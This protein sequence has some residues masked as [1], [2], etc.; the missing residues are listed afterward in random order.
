MKFRFFAI[1]ALLAAV[2]QAPE[3]EA[4]RLRA[5]AYPL[6]TI[7]PYTNVWSMTD[8]LYADDTRHWTGRQQPLTG[9][10]SVDG[11]D[12]RFMGRDFRY[13][14]ML[15]PNAEWGKW[16]GKYKKHFPGEG[17]ALESHDDSSWPPGRGSYATTW[18]DGKY[19][20]VKNEFCRPGGG[21]TWDCEDIWVRRYVDLPENLDGKD[22]WLDYCVEDKAEIFINGK[23]LMLADGGNDF[24]DHRLQPIPAGMLRPGRNLVAAHAHHDKGKYGIYDFA[25]LGSDRAAD[26]FPQAAVQTSVDYSA[27]QT[28]YTFD[29]GPV[30]LE[31]TFTAPF[32]PNDLELASRPVNYM[33]YKVKSTDG[34]AHTTALTLI[35]S[36]LHAVDFPG[37]PT[38]ER[39]E[40]TDGL[41]LMSTGTVQQ[42]TLEK[43]GD[44]RR[45]N[46]GR[47]YVAAPS[48]DTTFDVDGKE[49]KLT[50]QLGSAKEAEGFLMLGYDDVFSLN[51]M[52]TNLRPYWNRNGDQ[53]IL[54]QFLKA[55]AD[56]PRL[57]KECAKFDRKLYS[58]AK[59]AG[60]EDYA[61][62]CTLAWRQVMAAHKLCQAP[63]GVLIFPSKE[64]FSNGSIGTVDLSYPSIP[65]FLLYNVELAKG[66]INPIFEYCAS[67]AWNKPYA[68]HDVGRY[69]LALGQNYGGDMPVEESGNMLIMAAAIARA[70]GNA[71]YA[72]RY[73]PLLTQWA[74][75]LEEKG[76]DPENQLC[77][78]DFAGHL[79]HNANLSGKAILGLAA[80]GYLAGMR[81]DKD[82]EKKYMD[83]AREMAARW[84][85]MADDGNH[86]RLAFDKPGTWSQKY[87]LVWDKIFG[88]NIFPKEVYDKEIKYYL[89]HQNEYG[90]PLDCRETYTKTDWI[91]WT[92]TMAD[93]DRDFRALVHPVWKFMNETTDRKP[94]SDWPYT[95]RKIARQFRN[96]SVVGGYFIKMLE[97]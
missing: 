92:A 40:S 63:S 17:W 37:E 36:P 39:V 48:A 66:L 86:Y 11:K 15:V 74:N 42:R 73:W 83:M 59:K 55:Q 8:T 27:T 47:F 50:R 81:G 51:Y 91:L 58:D 6:V 90:L 65:M 54:S 52:G 77:T 5:P 31:V 78:D 33:S 56:Y 4:S 45:I 85:E 69:P 1:A 35:A 93:N 64:N 94:M 3:A 68:A 71:D 72:S 57:M 2:A 62:L 18:T 28:V 24:N 49:L 96:R 46:W 87:N 84:V 79:A 32:L 25:I 21:T 26:R 19:L 97:N 41:T 76:L 60:G 16:E 13:M 67:D 95:D 89:A 44:D 34:K 43:W 9:V 29:C 88:W 80:Y 75:F 12:Y 30:Q 23:R 70:E 61:D 53:T 20:K 10:L 82:T 7:D 22:L 14:E 38:D